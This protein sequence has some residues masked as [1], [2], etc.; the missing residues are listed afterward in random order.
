[1]ATLDDIVSAAA[2][3]FRTKGYHAATVRDIAEE[4]G[5]LKGSLYHHFESKEALLYL[6]V[7]EPI[8]RMYQ[9]IGAIADADLNSD[10]KAAPGDC[11]ASGSLRPPLPASVRLSARARV[12]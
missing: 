11:G 10:R 3:V 1:M 5:I 2:K 7:K 9:T 8:A 6:V 4:V 12:G